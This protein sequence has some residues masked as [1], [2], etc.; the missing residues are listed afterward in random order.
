MN[1]VIAQLK[2][3]HYFY[4][5]YKYV[6]VYNTDPTFV[7]QFFLNSKFTDLSKSLGELE[8]VIVINPVIFFK[9]RFHGTVTK[10]I[11]ENLKYVLDM[12][13][14]FRYFVVLSSKN[15]FNKCIPPATID[16]L[17]NKNEKEYSAVAPVFK[18]KEFIW[19]WGRFYKYS[20]LFIEH[21]RNNNWMLNP[22]DHEGLV[23]PYDTCVLIRQFWKDHKDIYDNAC[24]A[25]TCVEEYIPFT[26]AY[27][28]N[29]GRGACIG[30]S[31]YGLKSGMLSKMYNRDFDDPIMIELGNTYNYSI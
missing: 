17:I 20:H 29:K 21:C 31:A 14:K 12:D 24:S 9:Q 2:N 18:D 6:V 5:R 27:N 3:I 15:M 28:I 19:H 10:G 26:L 4:N 23:F 13:Y 30:S 1:C 16:E 7:N 25:L 11:M 22:A 8:K